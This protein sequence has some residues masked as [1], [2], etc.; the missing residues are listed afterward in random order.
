MDDSS[1]DL[2][3]K[4][5][6]DF[7][8]NHGLVLDV[9]NA[10][11]F[12]KGHIPGS[13]N[14][15]LNGSLAIWLGTLIHNLQ[16]PIVLIT[17]KGEE[18][19]T[20][21]RLARVGFENVLGFL[22]GGIE[23]WRDSGFSI[24]TTEEQSAI[25]FAEHIDS[26]KGVIL[27]VRGKGERE[28]GYLPD[29]QGLPLRDFPEQAKNLDKEKTYF[30]HCAGGYRSMIAASW[31]QKLGFQHVVNVKGGYNEIKKYLQPA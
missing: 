18:S 7:M 25:E 24:E 26:L 23:A 5:T 29:S 4:Q 2:N 15:G 11:D 30:I 21:V 28:T 20:I 14:I 19:T 27:D 17:P 6:A 16:Q 9:R 1:Q 22:K 31:L 10:D 8:A 3:A 13:I 12:A